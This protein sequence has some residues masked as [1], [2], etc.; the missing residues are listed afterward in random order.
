MKNYFDLENV[1]KTHVTTFIIRKIV[2]RLYAPGKNMY[3]D[4]L[5]TSQF[6]LKSTNVYDFVV[7]ITR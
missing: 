7:E 3:M 5:F 1:L 6:T 4:I 2:H